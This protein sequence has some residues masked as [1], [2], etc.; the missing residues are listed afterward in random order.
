MMS[1]AKIAI[2][3]SAG[4][5][6]FERR[7]NPRYH[8]VAEVEIVDLE[9][10]TTIT[11]RTS[12]FS[13]GGCYVDMLS[14]LPEDTVLKL[15]VTKWQQTL[16]TQAKVVYSS[17]GMGMGLMFGVLDAAQQVTIERWLTQLCGAQAC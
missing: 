1:A 2:S 7:G 14:P 5:R 17:V 12:D 10:A 15:R 11:A 3:A 9:S 13:G 8:F 4:P 6:Q 16:E